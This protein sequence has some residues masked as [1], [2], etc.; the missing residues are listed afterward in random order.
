M[1]QRGHVG[2]AGHPEGAPA[3]AQQPVPAHVR[4]VEGPAVRGEPDVLRLAARAEVAPTEHPVRRRRD[5]QQRPGEL[6][7]D[8][9]EPP[10][11][12]EVGVVGSVA[13]AVVDDSSPVERVR[14]GEDDL[15]VLLR[16]HHGPAAVGGEVEV[17]R[18]PLRD[19][20][21]DLPGGRVDRDQGV[22]LTGLD[23]EGAQ[24]PR[25]CDVLGQRAGVQDTHHLAGAL[26]DDR[27]DG[28]AVRVGDVE[29][30]RVGRHALTQESRGGVG[31]DL[32]GHRRGHPRERS[33]ERG[34]EPRH[35]RSGCR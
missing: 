20:P 33:A 27:G 9:E 1:R 8:D 4:D 13:A 19:P 3:D 26:V 24:V 29:V 31:V 34:G 17:V 18:P 16:H 10:V 11:G 32:A 7:G 22:G 23:V 5:L 35:R 6:A 12:R 28:R 30:R 21:F 14:V 25:R 15:V 2:A